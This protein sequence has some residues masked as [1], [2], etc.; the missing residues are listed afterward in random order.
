LGY[1]ELIREDMMHKQS[2]NVQF[3]EAIDAI[4]RNAK[5]LQRLTNNILD[6]SKIESQTLNLDKEVINLNE[7]ILRIVQDYKS[8]LRRHNSSISD[9]KSPVQLFSVTSQSEWQCLHFIFYTHSYYF[10]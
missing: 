2:T 10:F 7:L 3:I 9:K 4:H 1:V 6:V 5:R 8:Y